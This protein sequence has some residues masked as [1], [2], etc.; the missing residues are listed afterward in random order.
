[1]DWSQAESGGAFMIENNAEGTVSNTS[2]K[3]C[4]ASN[5]GGVLSVVQSGV[6]NL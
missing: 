4:R 3:G 5:K 6:V 2:F 1:M